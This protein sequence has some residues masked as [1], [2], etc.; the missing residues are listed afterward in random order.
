[1]T[2]VFVLDSLPPRRNWPTLL[3][4]EVAPCR[5]SSDQ[6]EPLQIDDAPCCD[7]ILVIHNSYFWSCFRGDDESKRTQAL[8]ALIQ[9]ASRRRNLISIAVSGAGES[10]ETPVEH[11][12]Y[13]R[14]AV[15]GDND[16]FFG[17]RF[18]AFRDR[19]LQYG[20]V[21]FSILE[22]DRVP[23]DLLSIYIASIL[24]SDAGIP[25]N[26]LARVIESQTWNIA[27]AQL[28]RL[29][30][31][32]EKNWG[33]YILTESDALESLIEV[34]ASHLVDVGPAVGTAPR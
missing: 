9:V 27:E 23:D 16:V 2:K 14:K 20:L 28:K 12:L 17:E 1:M 22:P 10:G 18:R 25:A 6:R 11:R 19:V 24:T 32:V 21:D 29:G 8:D 31:R 5:W 3:G 30:G 26:V 34:I 33:P 7:G 13:Y 4:V 15:L